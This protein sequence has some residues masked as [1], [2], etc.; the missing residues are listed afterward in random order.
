MAFVNYNNKEIT[1]KIVY[2][3]PALSGKTTCLRYIYSS[4]SL[5]K[6]G[7]LI[8]LDTDGDRTLFFD[9]LPIELGK[10]GDYSVKVQLYTVPGQVAYD[11]TRKLVLQG[12]DGI[13]YIADSQV[14]MREQNLESYNNLIKN[15]KLNNLAD[16]NIPIIL[17]FNKRDLTDVLTIDELNDSLN[18]DNKPFFPTIAT[19]GENVIEGLHSIMKMVIIN[20]KNKLTVF[21]KDKTVMFSKEEITAATDV[22][23]NEQN[24][25]ETSV[26]REENDI[27][28]LDDGD[29]IDEENNKDEIFSLDDVDII[30][31]VNEAVANVPDVVLTE[32]IVDEKHK[33]KSVKNKKVE[34][35]KTID[36]KEQAIGI[37][38]KGEVS[39]PVTVTIPDNRD[40]IKINLNLNIVLKKD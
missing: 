39:I 20:L 13:V 10:I 18:K 16:K 34:L 38:K 7:K 25:E 37:S 3:G 6:K 32:E 5:D 17:H 29:N 27:F 2:Y 33:N 21:Q 19:T 28:E 24:S 30:S 12:A 11:T 40:S 4:K 36:M 14:I 15:M 26:E 9:F 8:T 1:V 22:E 23:V 31:D 35:S